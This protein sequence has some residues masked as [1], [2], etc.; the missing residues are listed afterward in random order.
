MNERLLHDCAFTTATSLMQT[1]A[2]LFMDQEQQDAFD[3]LYENI[4]AG[5]ECYE[6]MKQRESIR[7]HPSRN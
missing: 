4:K 1:L 3:L 6:I 5:I 7:I 2:G